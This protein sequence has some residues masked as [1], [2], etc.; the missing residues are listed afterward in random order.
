MKERPKHTWLELVSLWLTD[1]AGKRSIE[2]DKDKLRWLSKLLGDMELGKINSQML[3]KIRAEKMKEGVSPTTVNRYMALLRSML[4]HAK[5]NDMIDD[6]PSF[7]GKLVAE[8]QERVV[9][10]TKEQATR[11][12]QYLPDNIK[13]PFMFA[14]MTGIRK[15]N[16]FTLTWAQVDLDR[17][18][19]WIK[20]EDAKGKKSITIPLNRNALERIKTIKGSAQHSRFVF[21]DSK[22]M[23]L[24]A[25]RRVLKQSGVGAEIKREFGVELRWHDIRHTWATWHVMGGTPLGELQKLG[26]WASYSMVLKYAHFAP[27]HLAQYADNVGVEL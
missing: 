25:W 13:D 12:Y 11:L 7:K 23:Q 21:G 27:A 20:A 10:L 19:A 8:N 9:Y 5:A 1:K 3:N 16:V 15:N 18:C 17:A 26:G 4:N 24:K 6:V 22:P 14:L 2:D